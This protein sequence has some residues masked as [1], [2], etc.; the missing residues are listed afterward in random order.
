MD[1]SRK[2]C[3]IIVKPLNTGIFDMLRRDILVALGGA[4]V[5]TTRLHAK[6]DKPAGV[7][8]IGVLWHAG[9]A[10]EESDY[11][12]VLRSAF[13]SLGY[14]EGKNINLEHRFPAEQAVT[15]F[16]LLSTPATNE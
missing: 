1:L 14:T 10:E 6:S 3:K 9:S 12:P 2:E 11:L 4:L 8:A 16:R 15:M 7:P 5:S 13:A